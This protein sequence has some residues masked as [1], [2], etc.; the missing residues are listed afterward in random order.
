MIRMKTNMAMRNLLNK[1]IQ[2][3]EPMDF[4]LFNPEFHEWDRCILVDASSLKN[5][6]SIDETGYQDRT[7]LEASINHYHIDSLET[8]LKLI[9]NWE[10]CL[11]FTYPK[12][13][14]ILI[15]SSTTDGENVVLRF[16]QY[17][18]D[19]PEWIQLNDLERYKE[20]AILIVEIFHEFRKVRKG[21]ST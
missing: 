7:D 19:E 18:N 8:G 14:F 9:S 11:R 21:R 12:R 16:Y 20:E 13:E 2:S 15:L 5:T 10:E 1:S 17:R 4:N 3:N 6:S